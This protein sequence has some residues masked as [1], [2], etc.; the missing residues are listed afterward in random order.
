MS[1]PGLMEIADA[2][3]RVEWRLR[4]KGWG[5]AKIYPFLSWV[6]EVRWPKQGLI[7]HAELEAIERDLE[8]LIQEFGAG[9]R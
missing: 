2:R 1:K 9:K 7:A 4:T 3:V 5:D 6:A 8:E